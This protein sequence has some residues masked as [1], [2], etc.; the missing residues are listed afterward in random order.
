MRLKNWDHTASKWQGLKLYPKLQ[1]QGTLNKQNCIGLEAQKY[2]CI[3]F[4][5]KLT[6]WYANLLCQSSPLLKMSQ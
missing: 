4:N 5:Q 2:I 6:H 1:T 3:M